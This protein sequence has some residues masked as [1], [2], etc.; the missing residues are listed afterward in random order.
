MYWIEL[1][2]CSFLFLCAA[3]V[4]CLIYVTTQTEHFLHQTRQYIANMYILIC[5]SI[6][7]FFFEWAFCQSYLFY[8]IQFMYVCTYQKKQVKIKIEVEGAEDYN[9]K[10]VAP[11]ILPMLSRPHRVSTRQ[12]CQKTQRTLQICAVEVH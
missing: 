11:L 5:S 3:C 8:R 6:K 1:K 9:S 12:L 4:V 2:W 7:N 10:I